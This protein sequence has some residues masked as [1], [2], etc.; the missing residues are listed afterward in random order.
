MGNST[1]AKALLYQTR[2]IED[3][4]AKVSVFFTSTNVVAIEDK[5]SMSLT[6]LFAG[7]GGTLNLYSGIS[8]IIIVELIDLFYRI[9]FIN[10]ET[11]TMKKSKMDQHSNV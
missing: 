6:T 1:E 10:Y 3:N 11:P 8:F 9:L 4:F 5:R 2:L 7:L